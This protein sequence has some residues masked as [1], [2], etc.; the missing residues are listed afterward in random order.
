MSAQRTAARFRSLRMPGEALNE[1]PA[2]LRDVDIETN[3]RVLPSGG[4]AAPIGDGLASGQGSREF[5][6]DTHAFGP[7]QARVLGD[8][9]RERIM[10]TASVDAGIH[11]GIGVNVELR[12]LHH[13][14]ADPAPARRDLL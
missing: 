4:G 10:Q 8:R 7:R 3:V 11:A 1:P 6:V 2:E 14:S 5:D 9:D 12:D 13:A